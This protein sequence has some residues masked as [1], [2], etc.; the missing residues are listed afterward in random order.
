MGEVDWLP[1]A[2]WDRADAAVGDAAVRMGA[3]IATTMEL[4]KMYLERLQSVADEGRPDLAAVVGVMET[5]LMDFREAA[6]PAARLLPGLDGYVKRAHEFGLRKAET[7]GAGG[8]SADEIAALHLYTCES[9]FYRR[10]N[11]ALRDPDRTG[12]KPYFPYL[13]LFLSAASRLPA[14][15]ESLY[16]GVALDLRAQY[17]RGGVVTWWGVSSC[18]PRLSVAQAFLGGRGRRT[19]FEVAPYRAVSIRN[20]SAFTGEEEY[21]L[22]PGTRL[23][24][25]H[26]SADRGGLCTIW[27][28]ELVDRRLVS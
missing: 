6:A 5:P 28:E 19:L 17:P 8:L 3:F 21:V 24:V 7:P 22:A 18:T 13:R 12:V 23:K 26:A 1:S 4:H 2:D 10:I 20:Y 14:R 9:C 25:T 11:A 16:R 27:L 15:R